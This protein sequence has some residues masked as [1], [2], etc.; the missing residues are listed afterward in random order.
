MDIGEYKRT[1]IVTP[2]IIPVPVRE[3]QEPAEQPQYSPVEA[4]AEPAKVDQ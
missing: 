4:P 3:R 1:V 2:Q